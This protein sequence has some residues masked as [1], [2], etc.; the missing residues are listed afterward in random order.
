MSCRLA[1]V[2]ALVL[3]TLAGPSVRAQIPF[4]QNLIPSR[5]SL[6]RLGLER[7]WTAVVP[8]RETER[9][10]RRQPQL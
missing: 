4:A 5:T 2:G 6:G 3:L 8:L 10:V 1:P 7:N 9:L